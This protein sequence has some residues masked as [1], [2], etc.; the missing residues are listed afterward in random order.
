MNF[1]R[2]NASLIFLAGYAFL[3][4]VS[5]CK[6][7]LSPR[8]NTFVVGKA[9]MERETNL[10]KS[11]DKLKRVESE[12]SVR[13]SA[14]EALKIMK[15]NAPKV[16]LNEYFNTIANA[17]NPT[18]ANNSITKALGMFASSNSR[19][20]MEVSEQ[21]GKKNYDKP[22]TILAYFNYLKTQK[23][24]LDD[25]KKLKMDANGKIIEVELQKNNPIPLQ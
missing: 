8:S 2:K 14:N 11:T 12:E 17:D 10:T 18:S 24:N 16:K 5:S 19:V 6:S 25:I 20:L 21:N 7:A 13:Q 1:T 3:S 4:L 23:K 9:K 15:E 22:T